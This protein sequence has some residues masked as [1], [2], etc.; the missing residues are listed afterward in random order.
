VKCLKSLLRAAGEAG[1]LSLTSDLV[2]AIDVKTVSSFQ[3]GENEVIIFDAVVCRMPKGS[4]F[5]LSNVTFVAEP[6]RLNLA[7]SRA[8]NCLFLVADLATAQPSKKEEGEAQVLVTAE[9]SKVKAK[10]N[11]YCETLDYWNREGC[12]CG[13]LGPTTSSHLWASDPACAP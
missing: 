3:S 8:R 9:G 11:K 7:V 4:D 5:A 2:R 10:I 1:V 12:T 13:Y 6:K